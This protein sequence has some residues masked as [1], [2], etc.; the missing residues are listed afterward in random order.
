MGYFAKKSDDGERHNF[1]IPAQ[2]L[3]TEIDKSL[4]LTSESI[5]WEENSVQ[6]TGLKKWTKTDSAMTYCRLLDW[7]LMLLVIN[8]IKDFNLNLTI[9]LGR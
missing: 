7:T 3:P 2:N 5:R 4:N 1:F 6:K 8:V 9:S